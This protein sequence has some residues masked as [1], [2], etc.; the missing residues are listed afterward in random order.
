MAWETLFIFLALLGNFF[1]L[2]PC[3]LISCQNEFFENSGDTIFVIQYG[4]RCFVQP[5]LGQPVCKGYQQTIIL[6][7]S[8]MFFWNHK[9]QATLSCNSSYYKY[10]WCLMSKILLLW[11]VTRKLQNIVKQLLS[12][13]S[14]NIMLIST[15][16][17]QYW[18]CFGQYWYPLVDIASYPIQ[19]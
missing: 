16:E 14:L 11:L 10:L 19:Q 12:I 6:D 5:D 13:A 17:F 7:S 3:L 2:F 4:S 9:C 1:Q 8:F 18:P 15:I